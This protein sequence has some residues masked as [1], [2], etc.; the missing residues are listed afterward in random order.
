MN[1]FTNIQKLPKGVVSYIREA[2]QELKNV[3][4]PSRRETVRYTVVILT[5]SLIVAFVTGVLDAA[6]TYIVQRFVI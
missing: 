5:V 4:W 6:F 3:Q 2:R 1:Y